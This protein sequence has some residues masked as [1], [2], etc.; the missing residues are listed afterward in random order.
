VVTALQS[1]S[2]Y[3]SFLGLILR[4]DVAVDLLAKFSHDILHTY[5]TQ[6]IVHS[7]V[8]EN[9]IVQDPVQMEAS[10]NKIL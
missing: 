4:H 2:D 10:D 9:V 6:A 1:N 7:F 3:K 5:E 8:F